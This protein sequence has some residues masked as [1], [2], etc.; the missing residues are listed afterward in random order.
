[1]LEWSSDFIMHVLLWCQ[2][3]PV[4]CTVVLAVVPRSSCPAPSVTEC[5]SC[6]CIH[7]LG[8]YH[9]LCVLACILHSEECAPN[10]S[11]GILSLFQ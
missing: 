3:N 8:I 7:G 5:R 4:Y 9:T 11:H 2:W 6:I 10:T 1:M